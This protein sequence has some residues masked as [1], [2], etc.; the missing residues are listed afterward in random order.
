MVIFIPLDLSVLEKIEF[1]GLDSDGTFPGL[2]QVVHI[3]NI[4]IKYST[5]YLF[6]SLQYTCMYNILTIFDQTMLLMHPEKRQICPL[7]RLKLRTIQ[8]I[9]NIMLCLIKACSLK[10]YIAHSEYKK[11]ETL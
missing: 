5:K 3:N 6:I 10:C 11:D 7:K 9:K 1:S 4:I 8:Q 2:F